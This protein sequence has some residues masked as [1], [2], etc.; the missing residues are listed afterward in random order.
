MS[1][2]V[3]FALAVLVLLAA[4]F[5]RMWDGTTLP[6][7]LNNNEITDLRIAEAVRR[8]RIE[9]FYDLGSEGREGLYHL[10][11]A[12]NTSIFG[13]GTVSYLIPS[14]SVGML[15]L[16]LVYTVAIR[17]FDPLAALASMAL[18]AFNMT[19]VVMS[20]S[21]GREVFVMALVAAVLLALIMVLPVY[22]QRFKREGTTPAVAALGALWGLGLY[23]HPA[24]LLIALFSMAFVA[25]M[26][27]SR[28]P[29]SSQRRNYI[30]FAILL[31]IIIATPYVISSI[32]LP[33]LAGAGRI[34]GHVDGYLRAIGDGLAGFSFVGDQNPANNL[35]GRPLMDLVSGVLALIGLITALRYWRMARF[36]LL[37]IA[38]V[39]LLP[40]ALLATGSPNFRAFAPLL[41][42]VALFFGVGV[43]TLIN[44]LRQRPR[45]IAY[46]G[47]LV[48]LIFNLQWLARDLFIAWPHHPEVQE[49]YHARVGRLARYL[50]LTADE[51]PSVVCARNLSQRIPVAELTGAQ[52]IVLMLNRQDA[53]IRYVDCNYGMV[54][55]GGGS[56]EQVILPEADTLDT[57][58]PYLLNW[59]RHGE[60]ISSP[61]L[62]ENG[63]IW[64]AVPTDLADTIGRFTT[65]APV[66][67]APETGIREPVSPPVAFG[68]NLA[69][70]GY[71]PDTSAVYQPG[72]V[73]TAITYWRVDGKLPPDLI[74]F[75]HIL[76]DPGASPVAQ[77]DTISVTPRQLLNRD[78]FIQVTQV[79]LPPSVP[80]GTY[81]LSVGAYQ[82]TSNQR[83]Q[84]LRDNQPE[85]DRLFLYPVRVAS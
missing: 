63:V 78:I 59:L 30:S 76:A 17:L 62:P 82:D 39:L 71:E 24:G 7:G 18:V 60:I 4:A 49:A 54:F 15:T 35:P 57:M 79:L 80:T 40:V 43:R 46:G 33:E 29:M 20:R 70:L 51:R 10:F 5:F 38:L 2:R 37:I 25:F 45:Q 65:T 28:H 27:L 48:L 53:P 14:L 66:R 23:L 50:D 74:L 55:I 52:L 64:L 34:L 84:A 68:G 44:S 21:L 69:F 77:R 13:S 42:L 9:V 67:Y 8:G 83:L 31:M 3:S 73:V 75:T 22:Q 19:A 47:L 58:H 85:G 56:F 12:A 6:P 72:G 11:L 32:R 41:P 16:A 26:I 81:T 1:G 61:D 36:A